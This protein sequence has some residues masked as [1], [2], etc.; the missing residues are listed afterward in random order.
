MKKNWY[1]NLK[2]ICGLS[3]CGSGH[4]PSSLLYPMSGRSEDSYIFFVCQ[5]VK[6]LVSESVTRSPIELFWTAKNMKNSKLK[7][8]KLMI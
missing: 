1:G 2:R 8:G 6:A 7:Y 5:L 4:V 3:F